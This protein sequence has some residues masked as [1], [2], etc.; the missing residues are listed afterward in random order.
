MNVKH[1]LINCTDRNVFVLE[2]KVPKRL[3]AKGAYHDTYGL[4]KYNRDVGNPYYELRP[5]PG[6]FEVTLRDE[7]IW[8]RRRSGKYP[9]VDYLRHR[10]EYIVACETNEDFMRLA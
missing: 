5:R 3:L 10:L 2:N 8:S 4:L 1:T 7:V 6:S 9:A